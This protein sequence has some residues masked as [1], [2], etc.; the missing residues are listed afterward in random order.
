MTTRK[1]PN[2]TYMGC[3]VDG[4]ARPHKGHGFCHMHLQRW[5]KHGDPLVTGYRGYC[6]PPATDPADRLATW[7]LTRGPDQCWPFNGTRTHDG[8][9]VLGDY[10]T[11][12]MV[13]VYAHRLAYES[14]HGPGSIP[15]GFEV[16]HL[17]FHRWC[18]NPAHLEPVTHAEN[19]RRSV[20][21]RLVRPQP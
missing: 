12:K 2:G 7:V 10:R 19:V 4:C 6:G 11:G 17:C 14:A 1:T 15:P 20:A 5:K 18:C 9:G 21:R 3:T 8:Y 16:D 13:N